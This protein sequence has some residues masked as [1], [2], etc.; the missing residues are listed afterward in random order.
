MQCKKVTLN[1]KPKD[2]IVTIW[3]TYGPYHIA[4]V[5]ALEEVFRNVSVICF[6]HCATNHK[7]YPFFRTTSMNGEVIVQK[8]A[9]ELTFTESFVS[10]LRLLK[11]HDPTLV[12]VCGYERPETLAAVIYA[13]WHHKACFLML[14][15]SYNSSGLF[16]VPNL[17]G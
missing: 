6:S 15:N 7:E 11:K 13:R 5:R 17:G 12:L 1:N 10:T 8:D 16:D 3:N 2:T 4:R 9:A 14:D